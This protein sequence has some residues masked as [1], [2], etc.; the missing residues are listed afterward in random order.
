M[1]DKT[2]IAWTSSTWNPLRGCT[3]VS[4]GCRFC[5]AESVAA[6]FSGPGLPYEGLARSTPNGARWTGELRLVE[7]HLEDP[8]RWRKP[9]RIFV[10]SMSDLFHEN[11]PDEW[12]DRIFAVM[13]LAPEHTFQVLT[14]RP[15]RMRAWAAR[16]NWS[17][18]VLCTEVYKTGGGT[19]DADPGGSL[20]WPLPNVWL[21]VSTE[22]Q[23]TADERIPILLDTP[24]AV[25]FVSA[26]PLLGPVLFDE[27]P[28]YWLGSASQSRGMHDGLDWIIAGGESGPNAR[29]CDVAW[30]RSIVEQ[31]RAAGTAC[32]TKQL[33]A[34]IVD[35]ND[36]GFDGASP[37]E[38]PESTETNESASWQGAPLR[39]FLNDRKGGDPGEWPEDLRVQEFPRALT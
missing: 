24:A 27:S 32:F 16:S 21:G 6:R 33:G 28:R 12:I 11:V 17:T 36:A 31:C 5:Y 3:R 15:E 22:D 30:I 26:E 25:R 1:G 19:L 14:K 39:V 13:A 37:R 8:L 18:T 38:W 9:R 7:K 34:H 29:P 20:G 10:N 23:K 4:E 35:R 2:N